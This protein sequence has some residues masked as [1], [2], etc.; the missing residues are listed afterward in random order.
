MKWARSRLQNKAARRGNAG[1]CL[2]LGATLLHIATPLF[3]RSR[4]P[5]KSLFAIRSS[6]R[7]IYGVEGIGARVARK[8]DK[9]FLTGKGRYV[10]DMKVPGMKYAVFVRS[11][12]AHAK[13]KSIDVSPQ[14]HAGRRR[15]ARSR[16]MKEDGIGSLISSALDDPFQGRLAD[17]H[18]RLASA[19]L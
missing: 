2:R 7:T 8:E 19:G 12:H 1:R 16:A 3:R 5:L 17:E 10:D 6:G 13:I 11:P 18:G 14:G 9:R 15:R 4:R